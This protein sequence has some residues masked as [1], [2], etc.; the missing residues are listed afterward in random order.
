MAGPLQGLRVVDLT[1]VLM[2]PFATQILGDL[3]ADVIKVESPEGD[4]VRHLGPMKNPGMSAGFLHTNRNKRSVVLD[5]KTDK[6]RAVFH[7]LIRS[8]DVFVSNVRP[9]ALRRLGLSAEALTRLKPDLIYLSLVGYGSDGPYANRAAYDD[10][11]QAA[12][13][14]PTLIAQVGEGVPRYIPLAI[15]DR[16]VGQAAATAITAALVH[17]LRTGQGQCIE[18]PMFETMVP[19]V[20]SEHMSGLTYEPAIAPAGYPRL[21]AA[22]R[23]AYPTSDGFVCALVYTDRHWKS[24]FTLIG[25][26][27]RV[28]NDPRLASIASRTQH[29]AALYAEVSDAL[30][31]HPTA[32]WLQALD[33]ADIPVMPLHTLESLMDDPHL[34]A[35]GF[36]R[37]L[38]HPT[39]GPIRDMAPLGRWSAT[40]TATRRPAPT[41]GEHTKEI[42]S[43][44]QNNDH[45]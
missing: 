18:V 9:A 24:F 33:A 26:P 36:F 20:L 19:Y 23:Q 40:P 14:I 32:Y 13:A 44:L 38:H 21:L 2:G 11:I 3:G 43:E 1:N 10:M 28:Q 22:S 16:I 15:V 39:E 12:C 5:L 41:L 7:A 42:L 35:T 45:K 34:K 29:I 37:T 17:R 31:R 4:T 6:D 27:E 8:A 30:K 25:Q